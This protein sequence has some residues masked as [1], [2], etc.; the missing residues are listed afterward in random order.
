MTP[1]ALNYRYRPME[2]G[3]A[4]DRLRALGLSDEQPFLLHVGGNE[5]Y[6]IGKVCCEFSITWPN[7]QVIERHRLF[8]VGKPWTLRMRNSV[9]EMGLVGGG[10]ELIEVSTS[11][12]EHSTR[13]L[14]R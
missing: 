5:W 8:M 9:E 13:R 11:C 2:P 10:K 3:E 1:N 14:K 12:C 7:C 4:G 6:K